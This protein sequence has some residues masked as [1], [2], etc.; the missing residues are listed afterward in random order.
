LISPLPDNG[1]DIHPVMTAGLSVTHDHPK[2]ECI[3]LFT[4]IFLAKMP[5]LDL[6]PPSCR[7]RRLQQGPSDGRHSDAMQVPC[8]RH[9]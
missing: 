7:S 1:G 6:V 2:V 3:T 4:L 8:R 9:P 5:I